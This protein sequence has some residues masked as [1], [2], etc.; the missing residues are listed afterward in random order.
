MLCYQGANPKDNGKHRVWLLGKRSLLFFYHR[1]NP[2]GYFCQHQA[3]RTKAQDYRDLIKYV[4]SKNKKCGYF[5]LM[6]WGNK[7]ALQHRK[8]ICNQL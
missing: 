1:L 3:P 8:F 5:P 7:K 6:T 4:C 2:L